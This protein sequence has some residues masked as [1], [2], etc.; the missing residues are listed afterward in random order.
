VKIKSSRGFT[1]IEL[2]IVLAIVG[3]GLSIAV[4]HYN[5]Y[6]DNTNLR[7]AARDISSD[8]SLYRQ[9]A[10]S[11]NIGYRINFNASANTYTIQKQTALASTIYND[12]TTKNVGAGNANIVISGTPGFSGGVTYVTFNP[13]GT[14]G[15]GSLMLKHTKRLSTATIT[16]NL[17][18]RVNVTYNLIYK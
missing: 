6:R 5:A 10:V 14:S 12:L 7:E 15:A 3:I 11:E 2:L 4:P 16:T 18:G 17:M 1:L 8:I 9:R 13:R